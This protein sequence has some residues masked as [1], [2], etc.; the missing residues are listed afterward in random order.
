[1]PACEMCGLETEN[2]M[3]SIVEGTMLSICKNCSKHGHIIEVRKP[4]INITKQI[5][6][7]QIIQEVI[8]VTVPDY[9]EKIKIAREKKEMTQEE[10]AKALAEKESI[11]HKL[12]SGHI[13]PNEK[14]T[15]KLEQ[16]L[17]IK[18]SEIQTPVLKKKSLD[19]K[20]NN[21]TIGD[22]LKI[23]DKK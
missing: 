10:L 14:L 18:I 20:S 4:D 15:R 9:A 19:F 1:M 6:S 22:L 12:E 17:N 8:E 5:S 13:E 16:F 7:P 21:L 2:L 11:I 23:K 3:D